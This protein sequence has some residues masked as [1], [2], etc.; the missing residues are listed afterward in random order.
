MGLCGKEFGALPN[1][2]ISRVAK[3]KVQTKDEINVIKNVDLLEEGLQL[4]IVR[5]GENTC[6]KC[7]RW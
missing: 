1:Y 6:Y 7:N 5:N 2:K 3:M 4:N